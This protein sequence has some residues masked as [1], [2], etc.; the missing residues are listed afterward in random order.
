MDCCGGYGGDEAHM[1]LHGDGVVEHRHYYG[2]MLLQPLQRPHRR[3]GDTKTIDG[4][5]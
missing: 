4:D 1:N 3:E 2:V 5:D